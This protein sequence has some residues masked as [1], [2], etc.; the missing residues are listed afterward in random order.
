MTPDDKHALQELL[1]GASAVVI[2]LILFITFIVTIGQDRGPASQF[3]TVD[4]YNECEV[5]EWGSPSGRLVYFL[6]CRQ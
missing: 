6:D 4:R 5:I 3:R 1:S 2:V